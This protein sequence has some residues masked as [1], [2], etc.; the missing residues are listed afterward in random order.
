MFLILN[1]AQSAKYGMICVINA[2]VDCIGTTNKLII[3]LYGKSRDG[4]LRRQVKG[5]VQVN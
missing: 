3:F 1:L 2:V 4:V 5:E